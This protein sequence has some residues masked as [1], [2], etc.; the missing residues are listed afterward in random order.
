MWRRIYHFFDR[1]EDRVRG[2]LSHCPILYAFFGGIGV[3]I[4]WRGVWHSVDWLH[5]LLAS[6]YFTGNPSMD[7]SS[8]GPWWD[9]P[10]SFL[11]GS[12]ML[13]ISGL[14]VSGFI[15]NEIIISGVRGEKKLSERTREEVEE[16]EGQI[17]RIETKVSK[18]LVSLVEIMQELRRLKREV[19]EVKEKQRSGGKA[20]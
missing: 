10:F 13:L 19:D 6:G 5:F 9:G 3:V 15:G 18:E 11:V 1:T 4:F 7:L 8:Y 12:I 20:K 14:F 16:E 17:H 2:A